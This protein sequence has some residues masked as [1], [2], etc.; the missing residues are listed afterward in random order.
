V[1]ATSGTTGP[2]NYTTLG[3]A[4]AAINAGTHTGAIDVSICA[5]V[6]EG[7][8]PATLNS[9]GAGSASYTSVNIYPLADGLTVSGATVSGKGLI[10][11]N[12]ADNVT[13]DGD[14]PNTAGINRN[15]TLQNTAVSTTNFAQ[16]IRIALATSVVTTADNCSFK[17]L[18]LQGNATG[19]N[20]A[21]AT[22]TA[23][24]E[25]TSYGILATA[26][27]SIVSA[28]TPPAAIASLTTTIAGVATA[29]NLTI[30]N[31]SITTAARAVAVQGAAATVFPG[32]LVENNTIG[33]VTAGA[34]DQVYSMGVTVQGSNNA[35]VRGNTVYVESFVATQI[36]A[37]EFGSISATGA[38]ATFEKNKVLRVRNSNP[39][40][41][42][43][44]GINLNGGNT[45]T[46]QNNFVLDIRNDQTAG[47]GAF[48]TTFGVMGIRVAAG[49]G[50]KI[51]HN[52]VHLFGVIPGT[53][54]TDLTMAFAIVATGQTGV[55]VRNNAFSNQLT[56][57]NPTGASTRHAVIFL[58]SGGTSAMNLTMNN[59]AYY[60]GPSIASPL[61]LLAQVGTVGGTGEFL[62]ANFN[63]GTTTPASNLRSYTSTLSAA[64]TNDNL[65][66]ATA[67][68]PPFTSN[69]DLHIPAA[70]A[71]QLE[72]GGASVGVTTDIDGQIRPGPP[73]SVNGGGSVPDIGADE[74]DGVI[75]DLVKPAINYTP[76]GNT[77]STANRSFNGVTITDL[78]G[79]NTTPGTKPRVYYKKSTDTNDL[80]AT[81]WKFVEANGSTSPFDFTI[82]Y[83]LLNAGS[84]SVGDT[85]QYF[86]VAQD[87]A[88]TPN[89]SINSGTF[90]APPTSVALTAAA[91]PIG[92]TINSYTIATAIS[93]AKTVCA[94]G[95]DYTGLT[96]A[97]GL[98]ADINSKIVTSNLTVSITS[99][100]MVEDGANALN[101]WSEEGVGGFTLTIQ[102]SG[103][104]TISGS[105]TTA[106]I[107]LNGADRVTIN[108]LNTGGNSLLIRNTSLTTGA[109]IQMINDASNNSILNSTIEGGNTNTSSGLIFI[110]A[111]ITTGNDNNM[112]SGNNI[113]DRTDV[114]GVPANLVVSLNGSLT[115]L[116]SNNTV[117]GNQLANFTANGFATS[118]AASS[119]NW[120][121]TNNDISQNATRAGNVFGINTGGMQ[122]TNLIS[123][124]SIH[125]FV[126]S[127][128]SAIL[129]FLVGNSANLTVSRNR[130]Y[131]FQ[132]TA[133]ATGIIEG[134]E[135]DGVNGGTPSITVVNNMVALAPTVATAQNIIGIHDFG[136]GGNVFTANN[137]TIYIGGTATGATSSW[138]LRRGD[139]APTTYTARNNIAFNN[140]TGGTGNHFAGG[141]QSANTG[142]FVSNFNFFAGTGATP[143]NFMDYGLF[144]ATGT[145]VSFAAWQTGPPA[146]DANSTAGTAASFVVSDIFVD[147]AITGD[148]HLKPTAGIGILGAGTPLGAV[149]IDF[150]NDPRPAANPD[151]GADELVQPVGGVIPAGTYYNAAGGTGDTLGGNVTITN[152]LWLTGMLS[153]GA[154]TLTIDCNGTVSGAS[155]TSF[156]IG[157]L[158]KNYCAA[159]VKGFEVGTANGYSPV[160]VNITAG[161]FPANFT[162]KAVQG[163]QPN[164]N[165]ATSLQRYWTLTEGGNIT[166]NLNFNYLDPTDI[167]GIE[168][169]YRLIR[170]S[171][172]VPVAFPNDCPTPAVNKACV[173]TVG[174]QASINGVTNFSDWTIGEISA[175]T[176][177]PA[178]ISGQVTTA[179]GAPLAGVTMYLSGARAARAITDAQGNYRFVN[180][181][182]DNFY[183]VT[184]SI[185]NYRFSPA[186][187]SFSLLA[188]MTDATF[189]GTRETVTSGNVIDTPEY[190]VR[191]HYLDF[192]GREP[193]A[194]G[195]VFW[196]DQILGCGNDF[197]C[198]ERRTINVSA[199]YFL[200]I[201]FKKT[202]GLVGSLYQA[203]YGRA[204]RF[205]EFMPDQARVARDV[206]VNQTGWQGVLAAN[207]QEFLDE[208]VQRAA[209]RAA[210]DNLSAE[211][212]VDTLISN[213][214]V[215]FT[216]DERQALIGGLGDGTLTR[217]GVLQRIAENEGFVRA[218][219][220]E[221]FV[222]MQ[223]FGYLR[224]DPDDSGLHFWLNKLNEFG[225]NFERAEMVKAFLVST[226]YR[227]RFRQ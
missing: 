87:L 34:T 49:T 208:W 118:A 103:P 216:A 114:V 13:I 95:C 88:A 50:H 161:T 196:S 70:T 63:P 180:V 15:L 221:A 4:F 43:A 6:S 65:S 129:G 160:S 171:G 188:N 115:I 162:V 165:P 192:L 14:N 79:V 214:G 151:V 51:Y 102:P 58:P 190:F 83:S 46:V 139:A 223:Y 128:A 226:E 47:T 156:I 31:N 145:P 200:S 186:S 10:E 217:A 8:T 169:N 183:T 132:T 148:L 64:G 32:L 131:N 94:S 55:D 194:A 127:G 56:G 187:R 85:I 111:G 71:T 153:T 42:G 152:T 86:V 25:N 150:D 78:S 11:L 140:R 62:A 203:S 100:L 124:N 158:Q 40:T 36:R 121:V 7:A 210:Y 193:D 45:H 135:F 18:I 68:A 98:F 179:S 76:L 175:P 116:N 89:V 144:S 1:T 23:G 182:T 35:I 28:T 75:V 27:A 117:S 12:G 72:S 59:N 215:E 16:V 108:G 29:T 218:R 60:Q 73:G 122:G 101:Q 213:T 172:G 168:T 52:S 138:A 176:A 104:R 96:P 5:S 146:R 204:P 82:N 99:D 166:A 170:V 2:T 39:A 41:F 105:N 67:V 141:D 33:N 159:G 3:A 112:I 195:L 130:I 178:S 181:D 91:F 197:N 201:E 219:F 38:T 109:V 97:G 174:N 191:Q 22:S 80:A 220:N 20:I 54:S 157:N 17:N 206:I 90:A 202:G 136:F 164:V 119:N 48:S 92:P 224:R 133:G 212:Y 110:G 227:D 207:T 77:T 155:P 123:G 9:S 81:G 143:A 53:V 57:G 44:Y 125:G 177:A 61:S 37:L 199:A 198:V 21:A 154:N 24:S 189:S 142:T 173:D 184:P 222:R 69:T 113:H 107:A 126:S 84:V 163:P 209:F 185:L 74:F 147:A 26:G 106:L 225:G 211:G 93:G 205:S 134:L 137:N 19:R 167:A 149:T 120:T 66:F 30:Q